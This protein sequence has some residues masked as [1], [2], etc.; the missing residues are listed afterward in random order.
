MKQLI[1]LLL[2]SYSII[3]SYGQDHIEVVKPE[4][5]THIPHDIEGCTGLFTFDTTNFKKKA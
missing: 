1:I 4:F 2:C 3:L 5:I